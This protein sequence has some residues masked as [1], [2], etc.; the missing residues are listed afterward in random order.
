MDKIIIIKIMKKLLFQL[1]KNNENH[2][3]INPNIGGKPLID[4]KLNNIIIL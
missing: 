4:K 3:I 1:K 2:F